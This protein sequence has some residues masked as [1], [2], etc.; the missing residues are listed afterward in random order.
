VVHLIR[1]PRWT[2]I[3][4]LLVLLA[5]CGESATLE[6]G[7][8][9]SVYGGYV[10]DAQHLADQL[11][12]R[13]MT[14]LKERRDLRGHEAWSTWNEDQRAEAAART[15]ALI[16]WSYR[17]G[18]RSEIEL[19]PGGR[20]TWFTSER[21]AKEQHDDA[22]PRPLAVTRDGLS[23]SGP[24]GHEV[25]LDAEPPPAPLPPHP[26]SEFTVVERVATGRFELQGTALTVWIEVSDGKVVPAEMQASQ[27]MTIENGLIVQEMAVAT[28]RMHRAPR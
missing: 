5:A 14:A 9:S 12:A 4:V 21:K 15:R 26:P 25:D 8:S 6:L 1:T 13:D 18:A 11:F 28:L 27:R 23:A 24:D 19:H 2:L 3:V 17:D 16:D 7:A 20:F 10:L 22:L